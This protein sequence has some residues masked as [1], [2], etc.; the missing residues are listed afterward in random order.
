ME[1]EGM[2][3]DQQEFEMARRFVRVAGKA[4][5]NVA[6]IPPAAN[7]LA[8]AKSAVISAIRSQVP[9][10]ASLSGSALPSRMTSG[11]RSGRW[12]RRGRKIIV[13]GV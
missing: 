1:F 10:M 4:A 6:V 7:S 9:G 13:L 12:I 5:R 11:R 3:P 8:A 2:D